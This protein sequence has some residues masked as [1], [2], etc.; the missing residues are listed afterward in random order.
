MYIVSNRITNIEWSYYF[1]DYFY[2]DNAQLKVIAPKLADSSFTS[3]VPGQV[4]T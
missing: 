3:A 4:N 2:R 1:I